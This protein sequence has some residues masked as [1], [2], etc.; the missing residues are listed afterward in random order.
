[1]NAESFTVAGRLEAIQAGEEA[2][3][4][5]LVAEA[6]RP[7]FAFAWRYLRN[8]ADAEDLVVETF[9][10]LHQARA[11]LRPDTNLSAWLFTTLSNLCHNRY[12]W[13]TRHREV[14]LDAP[15][16][17]PTGE[18]PAAGASPDRALE[19]DEAGAV[20]RAAIDQLPHDQRT[21]I[22]L[23]H[24]E[25]LS[26]REIGAI[27]GCS[28]RGVETRLYRARQQLRERLNPFFGETVEAKAE[29]LKAEGL[30]AEGLKG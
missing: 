27:V 19:R 25:H 21:V 15:S 7:L 12:R 16:P 3:F 23:H 11:R 24:Y 5:A 9:V 14:S 1:M 4:D 18:T 30:N 10:R 8:N 2:A 28:E 26:Y 29:G 17:T 20:L 6:Q 22:L 13:R